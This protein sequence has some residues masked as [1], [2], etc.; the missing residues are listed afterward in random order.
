MLISILLRLGLAGV[1][2]GPVWMTFGDYTAARLAGGAAATPV[3]GDFLHRLGEGATS[4][5]WHGETLVA[6]SVAAC[7][8]VCLARRIL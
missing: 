8:A 6:I 5:A 7:A 3:V 2:L 4:A 1:V